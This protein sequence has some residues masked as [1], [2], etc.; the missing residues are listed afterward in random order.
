MEIDQFVAFV[1]SQIHFRSGCFTSFGN[2]GFIDRKNVG[3]IVLNSI[4]NPLQSGF[5]IL[6]GIEINVVMRNQV[7][8]RTGEWGIFLSGAPKKNCGKKQQSQYIFS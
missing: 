8:I 2:T 7:M 4:L 1:K 3:I 5:Y 6:T